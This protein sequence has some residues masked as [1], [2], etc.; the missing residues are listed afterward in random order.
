MQAAPEKE[1]TRKEREQLEAQK[2]AV[3]D[4]EMVAKQLAQLELVKKR[5]AEQAQKRI[6]NDGWDRYAPVTEANHAPNTTWPP[7]EPAA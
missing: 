4:P 1:L 3:P 6:D 5:R 2:E 7:L